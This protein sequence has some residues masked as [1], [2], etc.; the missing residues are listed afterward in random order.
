MS[1]MD[2]VVKA[3]LSKTDNSTEVRRLHFSMSSAGEVKGKFEQLQAQ[4]ATSFPD[5]K[6]K[7]FIVSWKDSDGD[8]VLMSSD[9][10]LLEALSEMENKQL[11]VFITESPPELGDD[12][13]A[14][15]F[16]AKASK[17][18]ARGP[19][20]RVTEEEAGERSVQDEKGWKTS[21]RDLVPTKHRRWAK[22]HIRVWRQKNLSNGT[23][24]GSSDGEKGQKVTPEEAE[25]PPAYVKYLETQVFRLHKVWA[26]EKPGKVE[27]EFEEAKAAVPQAFQNWS[28]WYL[29]K[30]FG[31]NR[32]PRFRPV[33]GEKESKIKEAQDKQK[34]EKENAEDLPDK[35]ET[36]KEKEANA[37]KKEWKIMRKQIRD[38]VPPS[39]REW[40]K[41]FINQWRLDNL[42]E[43]D[44]S[45]Y[46][47]D[48]SSS[49]S[50]DSDDDK[51][52][53][54]DPKED[55]PRWLSL[56]LTQWHFN[57]RDTLLNQNPK[58][59]SQELKQFTDIQVPPS[60]RK[61]VKFY[62]N[63][64]LSKVK[65]DKQKEAEVLARRQ[66]YGWMAR[67]QEKWVAS[68][69]GAISASSGDDADINRSPEKKVKPV[70]GSSEKPKV[71]IER[72]QG[73]IDS[74]GEYE[75]EMP[76]QPHRKPPIEFRHWALEIFQ[77]WDGVTLGHGLAAK[78]QAASTEEDAEQD[79]PPGVLN[80][81]R[82]AMARIQIKRLRA[83]LREARREKQ[84]EAD[85]S[86]KDD[87]KKSSQKGD[88]AIKHPHQE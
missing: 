60:Y 57:Q 23:T 87:G 11:K 6:G 20:M 62:I 12:E 52:D 21:L 37:W 55:Y 40:T 19:W 61:W 22:D 2:F 85:L 71:I 1:T 78:S 15:L 86:K 82:K 54:S 34:K 72:L 24:T 5:L 44:K 59:A 64:A 42:E 17:R 43:A 81:M 31:P 33:K 69:D 53:K 47:S 63:R 80:W 45:R 73:I 13:T 29:K 49:S 68:Q 26:Q 8:Y 70:P 48:T 4:L 56:Y 51:G 46:I 79:I 38:A 66:Y 28:R 76:V 41:K 27:A 16:P 83:E 36:K 7:T 18:K 50:S 25:V 58:E 77:G 10:E 30:T 67:F 65:K 32:A 88:N 75:D 84:S 14:A 74:D 39:D 35:K 3:F 9:E